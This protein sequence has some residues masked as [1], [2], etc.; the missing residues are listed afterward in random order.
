MFPV[1]Q[2]C[3]LGTPI[4]AA[5]EAER[6]EVLV[7]VEPSVPVDEDLREEHADSLVSVAEAS[8]EEA[9]TAPALEDNPGNVPASP[10]KCIIELSDTEMSPVRP[11]SDRIA[12]L[13]QQLALLKLG[14]IVKACQE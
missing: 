14:L 9:S 1:L 13:K 12:L 10:E 6:E 3:Y 7:P 5:E 11:P 4:Q 2:F 8:A